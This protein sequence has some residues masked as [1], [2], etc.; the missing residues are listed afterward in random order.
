MTHFNIKTFTGSIQNQPSQLVNA[1]ELHERLQISTKF[2][3]WIA[4]RVSEYNFV[5]NLDFIEVLNVENVERGFFG[6]RQIEVKQYHLTLDMAKELCMLERSE[7]GQQARRY[8]IQ[9]E[10]EARANRQISAD[11]RH[12]PTP[13]E[14]NISKDRYI[15]LLENE[16][17]TLRCEPP[18]APKRKA[19]GNC[20]K[21]CT[22]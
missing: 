9:M 20:V 12:E 11:L 13:N 10:K 6:T 2:Q 19:I 14:I 5:E 1:R 22:N 21:T 8:F 17:R 16:N 4:R 3:D 18:P 15:E 7:L